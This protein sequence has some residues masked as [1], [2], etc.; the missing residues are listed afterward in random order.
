MGGGGGGDAT[1][2]DTNFKNYYQVDNCE[3]KKELTP[4]SFRYCD[5]ST[6]FGIKALFLISH[7]FVFH[8][9]TPRVHRKSRN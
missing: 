8:V 5:T 3:N 9:L 4:F 1:N 7:C 6:T 2:D